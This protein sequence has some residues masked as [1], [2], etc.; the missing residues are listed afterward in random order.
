MNTTCIIVFV[1]N[2]ELGK[3]KTRLAKTIGNEAA[4][5]VYKKLMHH[6]E[7]VLRSLKTDKIVYYSETI[8][9]S[10]IWDNTIYIKKLQKG[11]DLGE[12]MANAFK[13]SFASGYKNVIIVGSDLLDL[14]T[15]IIENAITALNINDA[16]IGPAEDGGYYLLGMKAFN[17]NVFKNKN[18][19]TDTIF[20]ETMKDFEVNKIK[21]LGSLNDIDYLEDLKPY[22]AFDYLFK[23]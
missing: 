1:R 22:K 23:H 17:D 5:K 12:R 20:A 14:N 15:D 8:Q 2:P 18:W 21:V 11:I 16:V 19:G 9:K 10:D 6:T 7:S 13:D 3:V 4:L